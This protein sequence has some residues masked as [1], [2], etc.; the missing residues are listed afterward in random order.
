MGPT[1]PGTRETKEGSRVPIN[2]SV[3]WSVDFN[4]M[5]QTMPRLAYSAQRHRSELTD[6]SDKEVLLAVREGDEVA[7][8]ELIQRKTNPLIQVAYRILGDLEEARDVVQVTFFKV[9]ENRESYDERFS[10]NTWIYR[11][12]SNLAIDQLRSRKSKESKHEPVKVH[13]REVLGGRERRDASRLAEEEVRGIFRELAQ[14]LTE[15]QRSVFV[16]REMQGL[17]SKEVA[18]IVGCRESTVRNHLFNARKVLRAELVERYPEYAPP[19]AQEV[20]S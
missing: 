16:L 7:L 9:W 19:S 20:D 11:I 5:S 14:E 6:A 10:P 15:K 18:E 4:D 13:L 12:A 17:S 1:L 8:D 2:A 3:P